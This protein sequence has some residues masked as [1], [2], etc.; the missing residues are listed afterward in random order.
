MLYFFD[1]GSQS[2]HSKLT[3]DG[4]DLMGERLA[5]EVGKLVTSLNQ[6]FRFVIYSY[7]V[8]IALCQFIFEYHAFIDPL[9]FTGCN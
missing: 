1:T 9:K 6:L 8:L 7:L 5:E 3:Y 4:V 2:N